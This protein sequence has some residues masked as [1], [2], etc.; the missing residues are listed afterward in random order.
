MSP[1]VALDPIVDFLMAHYDRQ[2]PNVTDF[3]RETFKYEA[4]TVV[5]RLLRAGAVVLLPF[6]STP[7]VTVTPTEYHSPEDPPSPKE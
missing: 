7:V 2:F 5:A 1:P 3:H 4:R 6:P